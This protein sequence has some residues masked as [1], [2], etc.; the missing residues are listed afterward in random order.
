MDNHSPINTHNIL[1][2]HPLQ[3]L[4]GRQVGSRR[5]RRP[6][7]G[8]GADGG[9][10]DS[11]T[12][13][14]CL[15]S[16]QRARRRSGRHQHQAPRA[17]PLDWRTP[18]TVVTASAASKHA[19]GGGGGGLR[20][21]AADAAAAT[22]PRSPPTRPVPGGGEDAPGGSVPAADGGGVAATGALTAGTDGRRC[23]VSALNGGPAQWRR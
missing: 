6:R 23:R 10:D 12:R 7:R 21:A 2:R 1:K 4:R 9:G 19:R 13:G 14:V 16:G 15:P 8:D 22:P 20:A 18:V 5:A 3:K 11:G 17:P